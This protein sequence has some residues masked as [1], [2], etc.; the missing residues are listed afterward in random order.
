MNLQVAYQAINKK[1]NNK[2]SVEEIQSFLVA[3]YEE[4]PSDDLCKDVIA[5]FDQTKDG[6]ISF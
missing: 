6:T 2:L 3:N 5:E 4:K 1:N